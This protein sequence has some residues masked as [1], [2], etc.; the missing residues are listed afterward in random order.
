MLALMVDGRPLVCVCQGKGTG[1]VGVSTQPGGHQ[2][3][4]LREA[5]ETEIRGQSDGFYCVC[6]QEYQVKMNKYAE[7][8]NNFGIICL[9]GGLSKKPH[10]RAAE[11]VS[12][13]LNDSTAQQTNLTNRILHLF[14]SL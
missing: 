2:I 4:P 6:L 10:R 11:T 12:I 7:R 3:R 1:A 8:N 13:I 9:P 5:E 14:M